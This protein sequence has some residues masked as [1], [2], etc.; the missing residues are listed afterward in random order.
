MNRM[1]ILYVHS[2]D[3]LYGSDRSLLYLLRRLDRGRF[4][5]WVV[6]PNDVRYEGLLSR[7]LESAGIRHRSLRLGVLRRRYM[8]PAGVARF[9]ANLTWSTAQL[10]RLIRRERIDLVHSNTSAVWGG[11]LASRLTHTWHVWQVREII[12]QPAWLS[13]VSAHMLDLFADEVLAISEAVKSH[14]CRL[15]PALEPKVR[16]VY[17]GVDT[18]QFTPTRDGS[19]VRQEFG[20]QPDEIL[21]GMAGRVSAWK[22]QGFLLEAASLLAPRAPRVRFAFVGGTAAGEES[23]IEELRR[24]AESLGLAPSVRIEG[25]RGDMP[26]VWAA[27][28]IAVL[29]SLDPEPFGRSALE[30]MATAKPVIATAHGG[31]LE[32]IRHGVNGLLVPPGDV[33]ALS[34]AIS[35]LV[36]N[37]DLRLALGAAGRSLVE[38]SFSQER[39]VRE[40]EALYERYVQRRRPQ[41]A[42]VQT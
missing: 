35:R 38:Q 13:R 9:A 31:P 27:L 16:V 7:E 24:R 33:D 36:E 34:Q 41:R 12:A 23:R 26:D 15:V 4:E 40:V 21:V 28:D 37:R 6:L 19:R 42:A 5:P 2:S 32:F 30:A 3:E 22:G 10:V 25:W 14:L 8:R 29:P 11:A 39:T 20:V 1:K 17:N 18:E